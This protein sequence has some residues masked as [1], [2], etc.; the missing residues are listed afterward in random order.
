M[1]SQ[2]PV[3]HLE[4]SSGVF[5][6]KTHDAVYHITVTQDS[7]LTRVVE[8]VVEKEVWQE[9]P[10][11]PPAPQAAPQPKDQESVFYR[12]ISEELYGEIGKLARQLSLSIKEIPSSISGANIQQTGQELEDA[13]GQL[14][15][16]VQMTEKATMDIMDMTES[17][18]EDLKSLSDGLSRL[19][20]MEFMARTDEEAQD[21]DWGR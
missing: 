3:I 7:S 20:T 15:D 14:E 13:K 6:I 12:D 18:Q 8:K 21:L 16:I 9:P 11:H 17:M 4:L 10:S 1:E 2:L 19:T 5:R